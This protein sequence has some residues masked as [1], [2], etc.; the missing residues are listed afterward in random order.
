MVSAAT[1]D[2]GNPQQNGIAQVGAAHMI[3]LRRLYCNRNGVFLM[4]D[5]PAPNVEPKKAELI[6]K[7]WLI[8]D[9]ILV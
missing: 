1:E 8:E 7:G 2:S 3:G 4:V 5:V 6:L 9:D